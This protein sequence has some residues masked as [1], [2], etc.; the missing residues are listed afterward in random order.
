M[1]TE[2]ASPIRDRIILTVIGAV[3]GLAAWALAEVLPDLVQN[4]RMLLFVIAATAGFF[5]TFLVATGPL[6]FARAALAAAV[7]AL[8]AAALLTW[9]SFRF[10]SIEGYLGTMHPLA[11]YGFILLISLPFL[12][13]AQRQGE[14]WRDYAALFWQSWNIVVRSVAAWMFVGAFWAVL[15]LSDALFGL[16]GLDIIEQTDRDRAGALRADRRGAGAGA[17]G[18]GRAVRLRVAVPDPAA[19]ALAVCRWCWS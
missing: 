9:A 11:A 19:V 14:G 12:I 5:T 8:P 16:V 15:F 18:G 4:E 6:P 17:G 2:T 10:D 13:A 3:A 7:A 1:A